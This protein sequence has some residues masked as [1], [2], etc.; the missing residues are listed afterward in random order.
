MHALYL[1]FTAVTK[2]FIKYNDY[3]CSQLK[4]SV[5]KM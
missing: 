2:G 1:K 5:P 3:A 4:W